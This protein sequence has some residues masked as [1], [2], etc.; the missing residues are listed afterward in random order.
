MI[1]SS[2]KGSR[3]GT[4]ISN[5][6]DYGAALFAQNGVDA[7]RK[8]ID[9]SGDGPNNMG[10][11]VTEARDRALA[12]GLVINGLPI[13]ISPSRAFKNLDRYY[14]DC[15]TGGPGSF[16]MPV[17]DV[18][19]FTTAIRRKLI[20]EVSGAPPEARI[21]PVAAA[22]PADCVGAQRDRRFQRGIGVPENG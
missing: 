11:P 6:L 16:V 20:L 8:V 14:A 12:Q 4:S 15:V 19:E 17:Y 3:F 2:R 18:A 21:V 22:T 13:L 1:S 9:V 7:W 10:G 5:A